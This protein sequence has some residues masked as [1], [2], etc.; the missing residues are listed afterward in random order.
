MILA[1]PARLAVTGHPERGSRSTR[2]CGPRSPGTPTAHR[3]AS[4]AWPTGDTLFAQATPDAGGQLKKALV[5]A[6]QCSDCLPVA[7]RSIYDPCW[8]RRQLYLAGRR[9]QAV[10]PTRCLTLPSLHHGRQHP[11]HVNDPQARRMIFRPREPMPHRP[12]RDWILSRSSRRGAVAV[13]SDL[14]RPGPLR[15][16]AWATL[17]NNA[18]N[19]AFAATAVVYLNQVHGISGSLIGIGF[20]VAATAALLASVPVGIFADLGNP[21]A[22]AGILAGAAGAASA[23]YTVV[24]GARS[25]IAVAVVYALL[26]RGSVVGRQTLIGVA[27]TGTHRT[28]ARALLRSVSNVGAAFGIAIAA[29]VLAVGT[30]TTYRILFVVNAFTYAF[31]GFLLSRVR[32]ARATAPEASGI[33]EAGGAGAGNGA[34]DSQSKV[35]VLRDFPYALVSGVNA[36]LTIHVVV[37]E[38]IIPLWV[39][40]RVEAP[41]SVVALLLL[42]NTA[43]VILFQV[44][45]SGPFTTV[46]KAVSGLRVTALL[47]AAMFLLL[48]LSSTA[49]A[50]GAIAF[51]VLAAGA[52][53]GAEMV[54]GAASWPLSYDLA[55]IGRMGEYQGFFGAAE[56]AVQIVGPAGLTLLLIDWQGPG[57]LILGVLFGIVAAIA[58]PLVRVRVAGRAVTTERH[59][60]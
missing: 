47:L 58:P 25:F 20:T 8:R 3:S 51:L 45:V 21:A 44:P 36:L 13:R 49:E 57:A 4:P 11:G 7:R 31:A 18:G 19:G 39:V 9:L 33:H 46:Q 35:A 2:P 27:F 48:Y 50:A 10:M 32:V 59:R 41:R 26:E 1:P 52:Q 15:T 42:A 30:A 53:T 22:Q 38:V 29:L 56:Q 17:V 24:T 54:Q 16:L 6:D 60:T 23:L 12:V 34:R 43:I 5:P 28:A 40:N 14:S 37:L 55:P